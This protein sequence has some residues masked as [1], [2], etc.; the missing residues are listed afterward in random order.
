MAKAR[1]SFARFKGEQ[2]V[3]LSQVG[4]WISSEI[5]SIMFVWLYDVEELVYPTM[6]Y[7]F[8]FSSQ[9][10]VVSLC[11]IILI[12]FFSD[13]QVLANELNIGYEDMSN[14]QASHF[15]FW[16][17]LPLAH[18]FMYVSLK[19][20]FLQI[21]K[22]NGVRIK[23]IHH[24]AHLIDCKILLYLIHFAFIFFCNVSHGCSI[25]FLLFSMQGQIS[26]FWIWRLLCC[27]FGERSCCCCIII[28]AERLWYSIWKIFWSFATICGFTR[29][30]RWPTT[31]PGIWW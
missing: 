9:I 14:Q 13:W 27:C 28:F 21:I 2:I 30:R 20:Y 19:W 7:H 24:L 25:A 15:N 8:A 11:S 10:F 29:S 17:W 1:Y 23:N 18:Y 16:D 12:Y 3:I 6:S 31:R 5:M 4:C 26:L 22:F